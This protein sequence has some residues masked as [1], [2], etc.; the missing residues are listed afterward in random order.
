CRGMNGKIKQASSLGMSFLYIRQY[1][2]K[3]LPNTVKTGP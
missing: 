2:K 1:C 3:V